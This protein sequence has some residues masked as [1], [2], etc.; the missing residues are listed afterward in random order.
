[1]TCVPTWP[2]F[3]SWSLTHV[4]DFF[5]R[6]PCW[7]STQWL[8]SSKW[9]ARGGRR[10]R[11]VHFCAVHSQ[12]LPKTV[13]ESVIE[14]GKFREMCFYEVF[15]KLCEGVEEVNTL[16]GDRWVSVFAPSGSFVDGLHEGRRP[17]TW[18][19]FH[20]PY[21]EHVEV[22]HVNGLFS[23]GLQ[24]S[25]C[26]AILACSLAWWQ[27]FNHFLGSLSGWGFVEFGIWDVRVRGVRWVEG[28]CDTIC[29]R[30][31]P[32]REKV[33][34]VIVCQVVSMRMPT[35][36]SNMGF[37]FYVSLCPHLFVSGNVGAHLW[38]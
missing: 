9:L 2:L 7:M 26:D 21:D 3:D 19:G 36:Y 33:I 11:C 27:V 13:G 22:D 35:F 31:I 16:V 20:F 12:C 23:A 1:M 5:L 17:G 15:K 29:W 30:F 6:P 32:R 38:G 10:S 24:N 14:F 34:S 25:I 28:L 4:H 8:S 37:P 18:I